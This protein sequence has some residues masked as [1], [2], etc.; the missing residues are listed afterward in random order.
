MVHHTASE[1]PRIPP[2]AAHNFSALELSLPPLVKYYGTNSGLPFK[3]DLQLD[4]T[5]Q[6]YVSAV[7]DLLQNM[8]DH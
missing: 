5:A 7:S 1:V 3:A 4:L 8:S 6:R 2:F